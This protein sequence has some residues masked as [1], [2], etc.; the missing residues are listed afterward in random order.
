M[1]PAQL[2][3]DTHV[4]LW[5]RGE[6]SR[7]SSE[8]RT[9]SSNAAVVFVSVASAWETAIKAS[10]GRLEIPESLESG[11]LDSGFEKLLISFSHA[12][13]VASLPLHHRDPFD[14]MLV[15]Q[16]QAEGLT[17]VTHDRV[18]APYDVEILWT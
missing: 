6:P 4:F 13:R 15:A 10:I 16:A 12:E 18:L 11:V 17:L 5:W 2:L 1:T 8:A 9:R 7:L 14:R 3:L